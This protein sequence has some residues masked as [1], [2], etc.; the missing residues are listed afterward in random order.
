MHHM[1]VDVLCVWVVC[2]VLRVVCVVC[3]VCVCSMLLL[4]Q[5]CMQHKCARAH[6]RRRSRGSRRL[7]LALQAPATTDKQPVLVALLHTAV[8][9]VDQPCALVVA[10]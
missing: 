8:M 9:A 5:H 10:R 7:R 6:C 2:S 4:A 1:C 3:V